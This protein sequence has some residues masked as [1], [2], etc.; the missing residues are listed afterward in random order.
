[1]KRNIVKVLSGF[2]IIG[3]L[4][5][6]SASANEYSGWNKM[7]GNWKYYNNSTYCTGWQQIN[8]NW[9]WFDA[10]GVMLTGWVN[11]GTG[12]Y[13]FDSS[14]IMSRNTW[15]GD[16]YLNSSG[17]WDSNAQRIQ[18]SI[19]PNLIGLDEKVAET[20]LSD[21]NLKAYINL[22][23]TE[24]EL[25]N[26]KVL[27]QSIEGASVKQ[28]TIV[29]IVVGKYVAKQDLT[30]TNENTDKNTGRT[31]SISAGNSATNN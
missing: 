10:D 17:A 19:V 13:H 28:G 1:M 27:S 18:Y 7:G 6:V 16:Y 14:G 21:A 24:N 22:K 12:W 3:S 29:T 4:F 30:K 5:S 11:E 15:I 23:D 31:P 8:N 2:L 25:Y 20:K 26:A 9:Y